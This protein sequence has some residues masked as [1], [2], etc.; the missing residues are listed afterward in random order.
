MAAHIAQVTHAA[1]AIEMGQATC[2]N[3]SSNKGIQPELK[4]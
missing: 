2:A 1:N 4:Q 3:W